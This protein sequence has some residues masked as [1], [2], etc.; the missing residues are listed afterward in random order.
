MFGSAAEGILIC[1]CASIVLAANPAF[2]AITGWR[3]DQVIGKLNP[4]IADELTDDGKSIEIAAAGEAG[5]AWSGELWAK[6]ADGTAFPA[7]VSVS[8]VRSPAGECE[9]RIYLFA[10]ISQRIAYERQIHYQ[11]R[12]DSLTRLVNRNTATRF[13]NRRCMRRRRP[14][15]A[16]RFCFST[17]IAS[18]M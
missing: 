18:R 6:R 12:Y 3:E 8:T 9:A 13:S 11:A 15:S 14:V 2:A 5:R 10:D 17:S 1:D 16:L 4:L 7:S